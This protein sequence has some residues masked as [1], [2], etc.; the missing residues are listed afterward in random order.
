MTDERQ[1]TADRERTGTG[2]ERKEEKRRRGEEDENGERGKRATD[3]E[4]EVKVS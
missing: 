3:R 4:E 2:I 1:Q